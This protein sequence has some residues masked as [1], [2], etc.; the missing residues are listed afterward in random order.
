MDIKDIADYLERDL[1][2]VRRLMADSLCTDVPL[3]DEVNKGILKH[4]GKQLRPMTALLIARACNGGCVKDPS[5]CYAAAA[6]LLHNATL[7]HD[8][9]VDDSPQRRGRPTTQALVGRKA[10]VLVGDFW[11]VRVMDA[12]MHYDPADRRVSRVFSRTFSDLAEGEMLQLQKAE[13]GDTCIDDYRKIIFCK[14]ASLF[15]AACQTAAISVGAPLEMESAAKDY[16]K[17]FG[18]AFQIKDDIL[19]YDGGDIGKPV[20]MDLMEQKMT[21]PLLGAFERCGSEQEKKVREKLRGI[22]SHP[23]YAAEIC[24]FVHENGGVT[25]AYDC[26][27]EYAEKA[28]K[29]LDAFPD[30]RDKELLKSLAGYLV[31]RER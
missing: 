25:Y 16:G 12:I 29:V 19:D 6:E 14:T 22:Q 10:S 9:V 8:D 31:S 15:E 17:Y 3:L 26:L 20:G 28:V 5:I 2:S 30:S 24:T 23:E 7:L 11:L 21:L 13:T 18:M 1:D 4:A 27:G